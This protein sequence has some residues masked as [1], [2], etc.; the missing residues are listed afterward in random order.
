M[1][2]QQ[3]FLGRGAS[4]DGETL[5]YSTQ[6]TYTSTVDPQASSLTVKVWGAGG[7]G[8]GEC[9]SNSFSGGSGGHVE[10]TIS[11][12]GGNTVTVYV[13]G[14]AAGSKTSPYSQAGYGAGNG[15][16]LSAVKYGSNIMVAGGGGGAGQ[17]GQGGFGGANGGGGSGSGPNNGG[18]GGTGSGGGGGGS[19]D[20][21][22]GSGDPWNNGSTLTNGGNSGGS[23]QNQGNRGGGGGAGYYGGG[24]GGGY[25]GGNCSGGAGGGGSGTISGSWSNTVSQTGQ[26]GTAGGR[27]AVDSGDPDYVSGRGGSNQDGL[28]VLIYS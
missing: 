12:T 4:Y 22:G 27:G 9:P 17:N 28:V 7:G 13:G 19:D 6:G 5:T 1:P 25:G 10:G 8:T 14:A 26:N 20:R 3:L 18:G 24:G 23:G 11:V 2:V 15:G 21:N 16:G